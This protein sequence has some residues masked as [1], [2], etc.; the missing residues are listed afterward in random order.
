MQVMVAGLEETAECGATKSCGGPGSFCAGRLR[1][2]GSGN[3]SQ[4]DLVER[5]HARGLGVHTYT[6]RNEVQP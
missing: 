6:H 4:S 5:A 1:A 3:T 2:S